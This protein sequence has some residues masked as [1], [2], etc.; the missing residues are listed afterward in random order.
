[1]QDGRATKRNG[2]AR[3]R[4]TKR[5]KD[6]GNLLGKNPVNQVS[7]SSRLTTIQIIGQ[8][9]AFYSQRIPESNCARKETVDIDFLATSRKIM[10]STRITKQPFP[11]KKE[12][13]PVGPVLKKIYQSNTYR[14]NFT[15]E[16][17]N[18]EARVQKNQ[19]V[20]DEQSC[21]FV[22]VDCQAIP[23]SNQG[24]QPRRDNSIPYL[25]VR[26]CRATSRERNF[27]KRIKAP[28]FL[29]AVLAIEMM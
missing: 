28:T 17:F 2:V 23:R 16:H 1:M 3:K 29:Q 13:K 14:K 21:I 7:V 5:L 26:K 6:K 27:I 22:F 20:K 18:K 25:D 19:Q 11:E 8:R 12:V 15:W 24:H 10:Q 9:K 4:S